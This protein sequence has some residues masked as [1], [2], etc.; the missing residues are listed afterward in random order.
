MGPPSCHRASYGRVLGADLIG[1]AFM[2]AAVGV[3]AAVGAGVGAASGTP[4]GPALGAFGGGAIGLLGGLYPEIL[5]KRAII[6]SGS[7]SNPGK[8]RIFGYSIAALGISAALGAAAQAI[9]PKAHPLGALA[10]IFGSPLLGKA[11]IQT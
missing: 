9:D 5:V 10:G 8:L 1:S 6:K 3:G 2:V 4:N 7:C 11:I